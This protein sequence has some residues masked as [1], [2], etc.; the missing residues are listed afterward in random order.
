MYGCDS[1]SLTPNPGS[2]GPLWLRQNVQCLQLPA[3]GLCCAP[4][5]AQHHK[6][7]KPDGSKRER[8]AKSLHV[9]ESTQDSIFLM[10]QMSKELL[11]NV[12][13]I[14]H[15]LSYDFCN[16]MQGEQK[17]TQPRTLFSGTHLTHSPAIDLP[18]SRHF[19]SAH[20]SSKWPKHSQSLTEIRLQVF[21]TKSSLLPR[22]DH[23][24]TRTANLFRETP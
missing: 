20:K 15:Q 6:R 24:A 4:Q 1:V 12:S 16:T 9:E 5:K 10:L 21:S 3:A 19:L 2:P 13:F 11:F 7:I 8:V 22:S 14:V 23:L 18:C 17:K